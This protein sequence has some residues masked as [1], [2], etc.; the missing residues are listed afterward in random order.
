M[1]SR[2]AVAGKSRQGAGGPGFAFDC[3]GAPLRGIAGICGARGRARAPV[4]RSA[5]A[6]SGGAFGVVAVVRLLVFAFGFAAF[7]G[8]ADSLP[9]ASGVFLRLD[10]RTRDSRIVCTEDR[11]ASVAGCLGAVAPKAAMI[12]TLPRASLPTPRR[13]QTCGRGRPRT[14]EIRALGATA[15]KAAKQNAA[16][17]QT[18]RELSDSFQSCGPPRSGG[19]SEGRRGDACGFGRVLARAGS[20]SGFPGGHRGG[21]VW[22]RDRPRLAPVAAATAGSHRAASAYAARRRNSLRGCPCI[23]PLSASA[24]T[25]S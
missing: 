12:G 7:A 10:S 23:P 16:Q 1:A 17:V 21:V 4:G 13:A 3:S 9:L 2:S 5:A 24:P 6:L 18:I 11:V 14:Q 8:D 22:R 25:S 20:G 15:S 19:G